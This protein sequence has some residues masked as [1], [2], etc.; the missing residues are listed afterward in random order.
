MPEEWISTA[1]AAARYGYSRAYLV[2]LAREKGLVRWRRRD[3]RSLEL[4]EADVAAFAASPFSTKTMD[5]MA[6]V[7]RFLASLPETK[8]K[9]GF[10]DLYVA[11]RNAG[12]RM[13]Y[14]RF[15][16]CA[17]RVRRAGS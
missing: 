14:Y 10:D 11:F 3:G 8:A 17:E 13:S 5:Q 2:R 15:R 12:Y 4:A 9:E 1:E 7:Q 16:R 6:E